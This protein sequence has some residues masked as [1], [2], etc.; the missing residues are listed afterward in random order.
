MNYINSIN[1][2]SVDSQ[3]VG[4]IIVIPVTGIEAQPIIAKYDRCE[5]CERQANNYE[6]FCPTCGG[7]IVEVTDKLKRFGNY[8]T[9]DVPLPDVRKEMTDLGIEYHL[10]FNENCD[11]E[12]NMVWKFVF[13]SYMTL[14]DQDYYRPFLEEFDLKQIQNDLDEAK[15]KFKTVLDK[16][17]GKVVFGIGG[18][19]SDW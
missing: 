7:K 18:E 12:D 3:T 6:K 10:P 11:I 5:K 9:E 17:N 8:E 16:Y 2:S 1:Y 13:K 14:G 19:Y 4:I 15:E